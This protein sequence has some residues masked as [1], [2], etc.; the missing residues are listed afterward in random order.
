MHLCAEVDVV[1]FSLHRAP[2]TMFDV[3][4]VAIVSAYTWADKLYTMEARAVTNGTFGQSATDALGSM[5]API[6][7]ASGQ[8]P[9]FTWL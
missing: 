4:N 1:L 5:P 7:G 6:A 3:A 8:F 2:W 9:L